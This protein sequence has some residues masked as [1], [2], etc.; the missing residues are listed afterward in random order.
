LT[1][2]TCGALYSNKVDEPGTLGAGYALSN[3]DV[4]ELKSEEGIV[5]FV[6]CV[7]E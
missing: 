5:L 3:A 2:E 7:R 4:M 1:V 6:N